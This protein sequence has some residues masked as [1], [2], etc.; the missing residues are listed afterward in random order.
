MSVECKFYNFQEMERKLLNLPAKVAKKVIRQALRV[1]AKVVEARAESTAR[2]R[3]GGTMGSLIAQAI[4]IATK[5][6]RRRGD[7]VLTVGP[8]A[9]FNPQLVYYSKGTAFDTT[10]RKQVAGRRAYIPAAIE[11]GHVGPGK[12]KSGSPK[13]AR[14]IPFM[15]SAYTSA[16]DSAIR[17]ASVAMKEGIERVAKEPA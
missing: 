2:V 6:K 10:T 7:Y 14:P 17:R 13:V 4:G 16:G 1:G 9:R 12:S 15:R 3:V 5:T 8:L 11:Y